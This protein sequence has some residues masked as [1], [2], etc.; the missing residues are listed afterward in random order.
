MP[1]ERAIRILRGLFPFP[2]ARSILLPP[3]TV[4]ARN[5]GSTN[6]FASV[7]Q[8]IIADDKAQQLFLEQLF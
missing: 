2:R 8:V 4:W 6:L 7:D 1:I 3:G 5:F